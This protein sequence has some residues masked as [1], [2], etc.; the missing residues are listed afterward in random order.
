MQPNWY[1]AAAPAALMALGAILPSSTSAE[2]SKLQSPG[3]LRPVSP[4]GLF[5]SGLLGASDFD[6]DE[7]KGR[8]TSDDLDKRMGAYEE[9]ARLLPSQAGARAALESWA[10]GTDELA[11]T[12]RLMLREAKQRPVDPFERMRAQMDALRGQ[13]GSGFFGPGSGLMPLDGFFGGRSIDDLLQNAAGGSQSSSLQISETPD[14]IRVEVTEKVGG[15]E[16]TEVYEASSREELLRQHPELERQLGSGLG[17]RIG[18]PM[19]MFGTPS[20]PRDRLGVYLTATDGA[21]GVPLTVQSVQH[22]SLAAALGVRAGDELVELDGR[23]LTTREDIAG[24]L[25]ARGVGDELRLIVIGS[26]GEL[27][28][29]VYQP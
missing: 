13:S 17:L 28:E 3:A 16:N 5:S 20:I 23:R 8:L 26:D 2:P 21:A 9:L 6:E 4:G 27:R 14:G 22:G 29:L 25:R 11:W 12:S 24:A 10:A 19:S 1:L 7:W 18:G 15:E